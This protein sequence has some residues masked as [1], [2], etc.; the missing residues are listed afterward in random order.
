MLAS[1]IAV[2]RSV[3]SGKDKWLLIV[4]FIACTLMSGPSVAMLYV[5]EKT[6]VNIG[7]TIFPPTVETDRD[8]NC[9][10]EGVD[11]FHD[12]FSPDKYILNIYCA[13]PARVYRDFANGKIDITVNVKSTESLSQN[14]LFSD[15]PYINLQVMLYSNN[16]Q[17]NG[18]IA[19][20]RQFNYHGAKQNLIDMG[21]VM[22]NQA[23]SKEA[24]TVFWRGGAQGLISYKMPYEHYYKLLKDAARLGAFE[25]QITAQELVTV[26][27]YFVVNKTNAQAESLLKRINEF[28]LSRMALLDDESL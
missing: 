4:V 20:I 17:P 8:G 11:L 7:L 22:L 5:D 23:N 1:C 13:T 25:G 9:F 6:A 15:I 18:T 3:T 28:N 26:P 14:V 12:I 19:A 21:Y 16:L 24:F 10:G 2:A 27:S